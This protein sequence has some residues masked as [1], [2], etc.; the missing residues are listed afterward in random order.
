MTVT[1]NIPEEFAR[2]LAVDDKGLAR[3]AIEA[4]AIEGVRSGKLTVFQ[5]R[6]LLGIDSRFEMDAFLKEHR[7][8]FEMT[9][10]D[11]LR[12]AEAAHSF[13]R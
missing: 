4:L 2:R 13:V 1:I 12:D 5:A 11:V 6:Q 10:E 8:Y 7:V 9:V 3:T